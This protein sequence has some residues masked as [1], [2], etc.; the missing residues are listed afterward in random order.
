MN[1]LIL[2][3]KLFCYFFAIVPIGVLA[4]K[5]EKTYRPNSI[6][7]QQTENYG[8][9]LGQDGKVKF[10]DKTSRDYNCKETIKG[11]LHHILPKQVIVDKFGVAIK[12]IRE[13]LPMTYSLIKNYLWKMARGGNISFKIENLDFVTGEGKTCDFAGATNLN[14]LI[15]WLPGNLFF[16]P[17]SEYTGGD[18][19]N[20]ID[21]RCFGYFLIHGF[22][23]VN[24]AESITDE[25][26]ND[27]C[28]IS[29]SDISIPQMAYLFVR[30]IIFKPFVYLESIK[31]LEVESKIWKPLQNVSN[32]TFHHYC[33]SNQF[34]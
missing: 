9:C 13:N 24:N 31:S 18:P 34:A 20:A 25:V 6:V 12:Y 14:S 2:F 29:R 15:T 3:A 30:W 17:L 11:T 1:Y 16:G 7:S 27:F 8:Y 4:C 23:F 28:K 10:I 5:L 22:D 19:G 21:Q 32:K 33:R 26:I